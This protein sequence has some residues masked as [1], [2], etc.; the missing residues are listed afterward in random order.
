[1]ARRTQRTRGGATRLA[2]AAAAAAAAAL[3]R[4]ARGEVRACSVALFRALAGAAPLQI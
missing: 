4:G 1:M 3:L 2:A